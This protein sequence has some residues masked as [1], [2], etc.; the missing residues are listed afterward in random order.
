MSHQHNNQVI[1]SE[2]GAYITK[3]PNCEHF[4]L[5]FGMAHLT[6]SNKQLRQFLKTL[7]KVRE[8]DYYQT[9]DG[10]MKVGIGVG[11]SNMQLC[12]L[13][14]ELNLLASIV[15]R[16]ILVETAHSIIKNN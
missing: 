12:L 2:D 13:K 4:N 9:Q 16:T 6:F 1:I 5:Y 8:K 11:S 14:T 7:M 15:Q 3:C 10:K